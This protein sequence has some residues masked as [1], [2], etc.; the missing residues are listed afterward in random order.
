MEAEEHKRC[1]DCAELV[2]AAARKCRFCGYRFDRAS[3]PA[4]SLFAMLR[5]PRSTTSMRE[6]LEGWGTELATDEEVVHFGYCSLDQRT[7]YLL[8]TDA[9]VAFYAGRGEERVIEWPRAQTRASDLPRRLGVRR[10]RLSGPGGEVTLSAFASGRV[11]A[12]VL[13]E[14]AQP[15]QPS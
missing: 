6:L 10:M 4:S 2:L 15:T 1:P 7:G 3:S 9:R 8:I 5:P 13:A 14:L 12:E 11:F